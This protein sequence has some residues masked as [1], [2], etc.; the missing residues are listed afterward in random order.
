MPDEARHL[1]VP[2][3]SWEPARCL[4][5]GRK[6]RATVSKPLFSEAGRLV[7][8]PRR[9]HWLCPDC[10]GDDGLHAKARMANVL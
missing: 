9:V 7:R 5:C 6:F 4:R 8:G 2:G 10:R 3:M 1:V